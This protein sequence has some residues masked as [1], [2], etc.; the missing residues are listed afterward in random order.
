MQVVQA[1]AEGSYSEQRANEL[2]EEFHQTY[3][4][5]AD[6]RISLENLNGPVHITV[7]DRNEVQVNAV[8]RAYKQE[9]LNEAKIE[10]SATAD[11]VRIKT[12]YPYD[13]LTF[14]DEDRGRYDNPAIVEYSIIV[15]RKARLDSIDL[16]NGSLDINGVEGD[17][18]ASSVNGRVTAHGLM[19]EAKLNTVNGQ[20]EATFA[21]LAQARA[22]S[23]GSVNGSVV[24]VIPSDAN[25]IVRAETISGGIRNDFGLPVDDGDYVGHSLYG[26]LGT[27]GPRIKLSNVNGGISIRRAQDGRPVSAAQNLLS[28][29]DKDKNKVYSDEDLAKMTADARELAEKVRREVDPEIRREVQRALRDSQREIEQAQREVQRETQRQIREQVRKERDG[30]RSRG[31]GINNRRFLNHESR[32]FP[33]AGIANI[34]VVTYDGFI[35]VHGWDKSEVTYTATKRG[36]DEAE[37]KGIRI[38][39]KQDGSSVSIIAEGDNS[40]GSVDLDVFVPR[41]ANI[42]VSSGDGRLSLQGVDGELTLRT[43]DGSI[44]VSDSR[45]QLQANTGDGSIHVSNFDGQ[46][47]ARTGDGSIT[48]DGKFTGLNARTGDGS[49]SLSVPQD[50]N[51]TV[52]T[53]TEELNN[54]GLP[55]SEDVAPSKRAKRW[56]VGRGGNVFVLATGDGNIA[57]RAR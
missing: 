15:P 29:K 31:E 23:L 7:S 34:N 5:A 28:Q 51:F 21:Q 32:T 37:V 48:L 56:K 24:V 54:E 9:R 16:V 17:V 52:E 33:V 36:N 30:S 45:G 3:P 44:E 6:G 38:E 26:Q 19:G 35:N 4:L 14:T 41:N 27:G 1:A 49:I 13:D 25:A 53:N 55:I 12:T 43:S 47:D 2:R 22:L 18:K 20:L 10:V 50:S 57:V 40:D 8:K 42:H 39:A 46:A 11:A